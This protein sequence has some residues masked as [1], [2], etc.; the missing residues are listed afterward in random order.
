MQG[1]IHASASQARNAGEDEPLESPELSSL[2]LSQ[3]EVANAFHLPMSRLISPTHVRPHQFRGGTPYYTCDVSD[4]V[5][6]E[7]V[8]DEAQRDEIG[9]GRDGRLE[10]WGLTGWYMTLLMKALGLH[11]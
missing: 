2:V 11:S 10:V 5:N 8:N 6:T 9:G 1:F 7:W 4:L 3:P